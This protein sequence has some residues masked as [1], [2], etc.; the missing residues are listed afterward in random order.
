[1]ERW[2][3]AMELTT[4]RLFPALA[5]RHLFENRTRRSVR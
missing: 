1:M 4:A 3:K 2:I 5:L